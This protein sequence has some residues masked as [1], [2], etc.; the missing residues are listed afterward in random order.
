MDS[1]RVF[2]FLNVLLFF[3]SCVSY[4]D[5]FESLMVQ[6]ASFIWLPFPLCNF[7][8]SFGYNN[9]VKVHR[10]YKLVYTS[11]CRTSFHPNSYKFVAALF[12]VT[13]VSVDFGHNRCSPMD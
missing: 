13:K 6:T 8:F 2:F 3:W 4:G 1:Q 5:C 7:T 12:D 10:Q 9:V 11:C